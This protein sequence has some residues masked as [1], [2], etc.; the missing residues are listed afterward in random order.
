MSSEAGHQLLESCPGSSW[1]WC[2]ASESLTRVWRKLEEGPAQGQSP[3]VDPASKL[4]GAKIQ[5]AYWFRSS[6]WEEGDFQQPSEVSCW[7]TWPCQSDCQKGQTYTS[8]C[9]SSPPH[10]RHVQQIHRHFL[11]WHVGTAAAAGGGAGTLRVLSSINRRVKLEPRDI[12]WLSALRM[13][14]KPSVTHFII[15]ENNNL[16]WDVS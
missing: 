13:K 12:S 4:T 5:T 16:P 6:P 2:R 15:Q 11:H 3:G 7:S 14:G 10:P 1:G 9:V 8:I